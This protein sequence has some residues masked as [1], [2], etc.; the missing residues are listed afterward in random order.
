MVAWHQAQAYC[1][2]HRLCCSFLLGCRVGIELSKVEVR[3]ENLTVEADVHVGGRALPTVLNSVR[4]FVEVRFCAATPHTVI[5]LNAIAAV[6]R[7]TWSC[8]EWSCMQSGFHMCRALMIEWWGAEQ[9]AEAA[10]HAQSEEEVPDPQWH[11]RRPQAGERLVIHQSLSH[12]SC[13]KGDSLWQFEVL[14]L[15][16]AEI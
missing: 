16:Q 12:R 8:I 1:V 13:R 5:S 4:N 14:S 10:H 9:P 3:F 11:Q 7:Y 2:T 15:L 6:R